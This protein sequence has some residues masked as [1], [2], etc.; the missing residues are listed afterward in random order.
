MSYLINGP[1]LYRCARR[2]LTEEVVALP[3]FRRPDRPWD[4]SAA[5][6]GADILQ[7]ILNASRAKCAFVTANARIEGI[8][9]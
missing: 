3:I 2:V 7:H 4:K 1:V 8:G 9:R 5:T 6:V